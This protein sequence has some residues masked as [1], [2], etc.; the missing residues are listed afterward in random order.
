MTNSK[1]LFR[2]LVA[3]VTLHT[4]GAEK[5]SIVYR[6]LENLLAVTR[7]D[8]AAEKTI[9]PDRLQEQQLKAM[10]QRIN[11]EEPV[12]Y[13]LGESDFYGRTFK[14][15][16]HVLI[17]RPETEELVRAVIQWMDGLPSPY[18]VDVGTGSGCI[19]ITLSLERPDARVSAIDV[20]TDALSLAAKNAAALGGNVS[21]ALSDV[22]T[23]EFPFEGLDIIVS[24]PPYITPREANAMA[25]NVLDHEPHI[26]LF[27]PAGDALVFYRAIAGHA[28]RTL[29]QGGRVA[30]EINEQYGNEVANLFRDHGFAGV[31]IVRDSSGKNRIVHGIF[32]A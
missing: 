3:S 20:S 16:R 21:F 17:P 19:A 12:Q 18:I 2:E 14:V 27:T 24:N 11:A 26:A 22:L 5:E 32:S 7:A 4:T 13:V 15:N 1:T 30:V 8:V 29:K 9:A 28:V 25:R 23:H 6:L 31:E 10:L